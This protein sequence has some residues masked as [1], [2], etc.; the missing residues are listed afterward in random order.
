MGIISPVG[1]NLPGTTNSQLHH[2]DEVSGTENSSVQLGR[3]SPRTQ[4][5]ATPAAATP[6]ASQNVRLSAGSSPRDLNNAQELVPDFITRTFADTSPGVSGR[7]EGD[8]RPTPGDSPPG[9]VRDSNIRLAQQVK[10]ELV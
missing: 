7:L 3:N 9:S 10:L 1:K 5:V 6:T 4:G 2:G 8:E